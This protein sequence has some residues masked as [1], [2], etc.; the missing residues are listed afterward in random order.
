MTTT[1]NEFRASFHVD[2]IPKAQPRPRAFA[3]KMGNGAVVAR[4]FDAGTAEGWKSLVASTGAS[5]RPAEPLE[6]P[7]EVML[8]F[9][10]PR[11]KS[12]SR[13]RDWHGPIPYTSRPDCDNLAKAVLDC[14]TQQGWWLDDSQVSRLS[15]E[16]CYHSIGQRP[17]ASVSV[18]AIWNHEPAEVPDA[19]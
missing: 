18:R 1:A 8:M 6:C 5:K 4:V 19:N 16:K 12:K 3:R 2:G 13:R 14:L 10:M 11:P 7:V 9:Y 17:G 15:I